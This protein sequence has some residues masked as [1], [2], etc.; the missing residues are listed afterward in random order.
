M[1]SGLQPLNYSMRWISI[2]GLV[3]SVAQQGNSNIYIHIFGVFSDN[4]YSI[5]TVARTSSERKQLPHST[6]KSSVAFGPMDRSQTI[7]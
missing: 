7:R 3:R 4:Y 5:G 2:D 6:T 1:L